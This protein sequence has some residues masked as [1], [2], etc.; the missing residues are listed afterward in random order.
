MI[1]AGWVQS[2]KGINKDREPGLCPT[3]KDPGV[4]VDLSMLI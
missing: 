3:P 4:Y 1:Q 2:H